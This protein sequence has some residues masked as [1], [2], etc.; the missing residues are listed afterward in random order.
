MPKSQ[1]VR[2]VTIVDIQHAPDI[3]VNGICV[4]IYRTRNNFN[5]EVRHVNEVNIYAF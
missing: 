3:P 1:L 5:A 2:R 4:I